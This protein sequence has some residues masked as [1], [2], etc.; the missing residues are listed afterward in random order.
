MISYKTDVLKLEGIHC[1]AHG[2]FAARMLVNKG[3]E[4]FELSILVD[5]L[6]ILSTARKVKSSV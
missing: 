4:L 5:F 1:F 2:H 6:K 3:A